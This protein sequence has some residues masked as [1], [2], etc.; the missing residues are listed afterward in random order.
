MAS[1]GSNLQD[2]QKSMQKLL[3]LKADILC[4]GHFGVFQ[5]ADKVYSYIK[6]YKD[7]NLP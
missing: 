6:G 7:S 4:E 2:Y 1:F 5:P 3:D